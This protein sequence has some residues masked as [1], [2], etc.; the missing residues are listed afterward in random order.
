MISRRG[1]VAIL[2]IG[3]GLSLAAPLAA[4]EQLAGL[5]E[6][7]ERKLTILRKGEAIGSHHIRFRRMGDR[8]EMSVE[9]V[10][11]VKLLGITL[12]RFSH[13][14]MERWAAGQLVSM[15][16]STDDDGDLHQVNARRSADGVLA[17]TGN[18]AAAAVAG[19]SI[20]SSLWH[21]DLLLQRP[22]D[23]ILHTI[24]GGL[25]AMTVTD[26]GRKELQLGGRAFAAQ[27][28]EVDARPDFY[29]ELWYDDE[30]LLVAAKL[31]ADDG[32][33]VTLELE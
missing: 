27:G 13:K 32:S 12:F 5:P 11:E 24:H 25:L 17:I 26:L 21:R 28:Y 14:G 29:R 22:R 6:F 23:E 18:G 15:A 33:A 8:L 9:A 7:G 10:A 31:S 19:D 30:G 20:P 16:T 4:A 3:C 2:A 1:I